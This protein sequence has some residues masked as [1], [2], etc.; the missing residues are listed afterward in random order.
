MP[1]NSGAFAYE[2]LYQY[3]E[4]YIGHLYDTVCTTHI[5]ENGSSTQ[6]LKVVPVLDA[7]Y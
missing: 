4:I 7:N 2:Q 5:D 1:P 3:G 6:Y